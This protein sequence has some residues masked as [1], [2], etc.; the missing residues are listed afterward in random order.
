M[1]IHRDPGGDSYLFAW[2]IKPI[3]T[4]TYFQ[5]GYNSSTAIPQGLGIQIHK[6]MGAKPIP[7]ATIMLRDFSASVELI[8]WFLPLSSGSQLI[9]IPNLPNLNDLCKFELNQIHHRGFFTYVYIQLA[10]IIIILGVFFILC[11]SGILFCIFSGFLVSMLVV[12]W[13][14]LHWL[15]L[16]VFFMFSFWIC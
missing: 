9:T 8:M 2:T 7:I 15:S 10:I 1:L 5:N 16:G 3:L 12:D 14:W 13:Y 11:S 6:S 4:V